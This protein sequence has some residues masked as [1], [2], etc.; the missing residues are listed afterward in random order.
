M[1]QTESPKQQTNPWRWALLVAAVVLTGY[2]V[3]IAGGLADRMNSPSSAVPTRQLPSASQGVVCAVSPDVPLEARVDVRI[4]TEQGEGLR[5]ARRTT[6]T[7]DEQG[8]H[9]PAGTPFG[10]GTISLGNA[11]YAAFDFAESGC[12]MVRRLPPEL[13]LDADEDTA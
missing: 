10:N 8:L 12:T 4:Q 3:Y 11:E 5:I 9:L 6:A 1:V 7:V 13:K 2:S